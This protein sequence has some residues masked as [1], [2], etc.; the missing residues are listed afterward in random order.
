MC[1]TALAASD[2]IAGDS[3]IFSRQAMNTQKWARLALSFEVIP[4]RN[5]D[6]R[7][8]MDHVVETLTAY[9]P[10]YIA[11]TSS[12]RSRWLEGTSALVK[13]LTE[14]SRVRPLA[15]LACTA[16]TEAEIRD[17]VQEL[18]DAG[19]RGFLALRGDLPEGLD[20]LPEGYLQHATDLVASIRELESE[21]ACRFAGGNLAVGVACYPAGHAESE[22]WEEDIRILKLKQDTGADFAITQMYFDVEQF[23]RMLTDA[24]AAGVTIPLIPGIMPVTSLARAEKMAQLSGFELPSHI[25]AA[26]EAAG[27]ENEYEV[28]MELTAQLAAQSLAA[29]AGGL[30][31]Y[32]HNHVDVTVDLLDRITT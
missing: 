19:V 22:N 30:H 6:D 25:R 16:G 13:H 4:P 20:R 17:G 10:D 5:P 29:G 14:H 32:T 11:V 23:A 7:S 18:I 21:Q 9:N 26:L 8:K 15:H 12:L 24:R 27:P 3:A 31:I 1:A 2:K 28:G